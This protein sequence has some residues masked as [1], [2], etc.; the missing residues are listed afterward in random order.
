VGPFSGFPARLV[1]FIQEARHA[2][3]KQRHGIAAFATGNDF[4]TGR[5]V[6]TLRVF[7]LLCVSIIV[8][9]NDRSI[10]IDDRQSCWYTPQDS[11]DPGRGETEVQQ[12]Y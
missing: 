6:D 3:G 5:S 7:E 2:A 8:P 10:L 9:V 1:V 12:L 4:H 11:L